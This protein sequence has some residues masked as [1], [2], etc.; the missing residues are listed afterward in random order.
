MVQEMEKRS[1]YAKAVIAA[2][3]R[4][5]KE[6]DAA[7]AECREAFKA[8]NDRYRQRMDQA[9]HIYDEELKAARIEYKGGE[10]TV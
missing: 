1:A 9:M 6:R 7:D 5:R 2:G 8:A 10:D 3:D 4:L